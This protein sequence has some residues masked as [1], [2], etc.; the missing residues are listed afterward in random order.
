MRVFLA[1]SL[2]F[3]A[4]LSASSFL[5]FSSCLSSYKAWPAAVSKR[6]STAPRPLGRARACALTCFAAGGVWRGGFG[7]A[8]AG[9]SYRACP[10][11]SPARVIEAAARLPFAFAS[12]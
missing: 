12:L 5:S 2:S 7:G 8:V 10:W 1:P 3:D 4:N 11:C 6:R 9:N